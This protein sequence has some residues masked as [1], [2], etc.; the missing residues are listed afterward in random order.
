MVLFTGKLGILTV[1][2]I[3]TFLPILYESFAFKDE[4]KIGWWKGVWYAALPYLAFTVIY[5]SIWWVMHSYFDT[6][7][8]GL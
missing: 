7:I 8:G 4:L 3:G 5:I 1:A 6:D 2:L